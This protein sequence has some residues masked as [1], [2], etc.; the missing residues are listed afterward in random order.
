MYI[1]PVQGIN[2]TSVLRGVFGMCVLIFIA[3]LLSKD[4]KKIDWKIVATGLSLQIILAFGMLYIPAFQY[5]FEFLGKIFVKIL[6]FT[7]QGTSFLAGGLLDT[8]KSGYIFIFQVLPTLIFFSA[9]ISLLYYLNIIQRIVQG[10]G[11]CIRKIFRLSGAEGLTVAGNIFLG[12]CEAPILVKRYLSSMNRSEMFLVMSVGMATISGGVM[13]A[14]IGML[15]GNDPVA[16]LQFAK[17]L[18]SASVMAAPGAIVF[19]KI[20]IPQTEPLSHDKI[21]ISRDKTG[22]NV[23]DAIS[24]GA[25]EGL[26]LAVTVAALLLVF[27]AMVALLNYLLGDLIGR[28]TGLNRWLSEMAGHPVTFNFQTLIGWIFTPVAWIMGV[29]NDDAGYVGSLLGTKIVLN[30]FVAYADLN[31]LKNASLFVQEKSIIIATFVLCGFANIS[32]IGM[33]IGGIG[34]LA[35]DQRKTLTRYGFLAMI[36]GTL[37]S[38]MSAT[39]VGMIIG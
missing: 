1:T 7:R 29:C 22:K 32:S 10:I 38:C 34:V 8:S 15:G 12:M 17:Y 26:K 2:L 36:C 23:L 33:Q 9:L 13:A 4:R 31:M 18:I 14:Y 28:Y 37:A 30:E 25:I 20:I 35:P 3:W 27:I 21:T 11:W 5:F 16:R 24:N 6:E 39:I 19:S